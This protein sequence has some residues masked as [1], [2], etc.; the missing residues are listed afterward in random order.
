[1]GAFVI[2]ELNWQT[3]H[4]GGSNDLVDLSQDHPGFLDLEYRSRRNNIAQ[5]ALQYK[6]GIPIPIVE[7]SEEEDA[8]W[9]KVL[10][11]L[12]PLHTEHACV[13][14]SQLQQITPFPTQR[15]PQLREINSQLIT[16]AGFRM[17]PVAGLVSARTF[18]RY[19][20]RRIFLSTQYIRHH[21]KP[22]YTPEPDIIHELIGHTATLAHPGIAEINRLLGLATDVASE[23][24][25]QRLANVYWYTLEFGMVEERGELKVFGAGL[26]SSVDELQRSFSVRLEPWDLD[27]MASTSFNTS[28]FQDALFVAPSFTRLLTDLSAWLRT[29]CWRDND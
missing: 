11:T 1:M 16:H 21:S 3:K 5:I 26:L 28:N 24:E 29:G 13:E 6:S 19:L 2:Q 15:V 17:E 8:V 22:F 27:V 18:M 10:T 12:Q 20:G 23:T 9:N 14:I 25:L 4:A 7:Y